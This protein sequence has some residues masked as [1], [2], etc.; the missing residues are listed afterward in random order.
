YCSSQETGLSNGDLM[1]VCSSYV[2]D[3]DLRDFF[4]TWNVGETSATTPDGT[5]VYS[6]GISDK[7]IGVLDSLKLSKPE[8]SPLKVDSLNYGSIN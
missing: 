5:K 7:A 2:S 1:M 4:T 3:Y 6:G 8:N